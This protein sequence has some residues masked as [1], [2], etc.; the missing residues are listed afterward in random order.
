[1]WELNTQYCNGLRWVWPSKALSGVSEFSAIIKLFLYT[2]RAQF[3]NLAVQKSSLTATSLAFYSKLKKKNANWRSNYHNKSWMWMWTTSAW[4]TLSWVQGE[5]CTGRRHG[6]T[7]RGGK[8][9]QEGYP[10]ESVSSG[11]GTTGM[12]YPFPWLLS[13][14]GLIMLSCIVFFCLFVCSFF[15]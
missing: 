13:A 6:L 2:I 4:L 12:T 5:K 1:M 10:Q 3:E 11:A 14:F 7:G 8:D 9:Q 15:S